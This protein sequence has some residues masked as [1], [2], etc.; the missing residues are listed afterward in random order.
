M[1]KKISEKQKEE[2]KLDFINGKTLEELSDK[3]KFTKLTISR[4]LKKNLGE[5][6]YNSFLNKYSKKQLNHKLLSIKDS[7]EKTL[8]ENLSITDSVKEYSLETEL[9][10]IDSFIEIAPLNFEIENVPQKDLSSIPIS[11]FDFPKI[12]YMVVDKKIE[13]ETKLL[14][15]FS[16]WQFLSQDELQRK[17]IEVFVDLKIAK[18]YCNK[19][20]KVIK[21]PN[22]NVF[23]IVAP[24]LLNKGI[25]RIVSAENLIAL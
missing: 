1:P 14:K 24:I 9:N 7:K 3:F 6:K 19:D 11:E 22:T 2:I 18:R 5:E 17:T 20:Q 15:E 16:E 23:K 8:K 10:P 12:V 4:N 13:L 25:S 21:V